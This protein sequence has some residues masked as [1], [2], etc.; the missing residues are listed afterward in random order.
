MTDPTLPSVSANID[1]IG[2][3]SHSSPPAK[4]DIEIVTAHTGDEAQESAEAQG[5]EVDVIMPTSPGN[6]NVDLA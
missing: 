6:F 5:F 3:G 4:A 1:I 2:S